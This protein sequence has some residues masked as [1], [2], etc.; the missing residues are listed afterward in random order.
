MTPADIPAVVE[1]DN[2][3][4]PTPGRAQL[5]EHELTGNE[6]ASYQVLYDRPAGAADKVVGHAGYWLIGDELHVSTIAVHPACRGHGLGELLFLNMLYQ[7]CAL[8]AALVTLEVRRSN[9][10]AQALYQKYRLAVAGERPRYY[11]DNR[12]DALLMTVFLDAAYSHWFEEMRQSL[13]GRLSTA[14]N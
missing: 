3:S 5:Y 10:V 12:E 1:I 6:L 2:L 14:G 4:F 11:Q 9:T 8:P 7:A 13:F